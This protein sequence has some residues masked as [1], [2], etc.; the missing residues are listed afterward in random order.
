MKKDKKTIKADEEEKKAWSKSGK[1]GKSQEH[2]EEKKPTGKKL[3]ESPAKAWKDSKG[4]K[5]EKSATKSEE[6]KSKPKKDSAAP[7]KVP[8]EYASFTKLF[9]NEICGEG[10]E[11]S[12][13]VKKIKA[14]YDTITDKQ[15]KQIEKYQEDYK[16]KFDKWT[17]EYE[18]KGFYIDDDGIQSNIKAL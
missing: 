9:G 16:K 8:N 11:F 3:K 12:E 4:R 13:R 6:E 14:A 2:E 17:K 7:K 10:T 18:K 1:W 5:R 15:K